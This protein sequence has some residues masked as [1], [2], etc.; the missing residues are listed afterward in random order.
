MHVQEHSEKTA[1]ESWCSY[2]K[3]HQGKISMP[4]RIHLDVFA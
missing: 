2:L 3:I 1:R 4:Y